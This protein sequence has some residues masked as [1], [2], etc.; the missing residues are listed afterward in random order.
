MDIQKL[1]QEEQ[2]KLRAKNKREKEEK[3]RRER[4]A[5]ENDPDTIMQNEMRGLLPTI[6]RTLENFSAGANA[7]CL[8]FYR[9]SKEPPPNNHLAIYFIFTKKGL[10]FKK[11][12]LLIAQ[13]L[14]GVRAGAVVHPES[15]FI[16][17]CRLALVHY[18]REERVE[19]NTLPE[20]DK[21][22]EWLVRELAKFYAK[23][24]PK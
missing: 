11:P 15:R 1:I 6:V 16:K 9:N 24:S 21:L 20:K 14:I 12:D 18:E 3:E 22:E 5:Y 13:I 7:I 23:L 17:S 2:E 4:E 10:V 8:D 19:F